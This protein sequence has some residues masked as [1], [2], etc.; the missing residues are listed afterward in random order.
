MLEMPQELMTPAEAAR[1]FRRSTSWLRRHPEVV[2]LRQSGGPP[3]YHIRTCR[4]YVL[5]RIC[6]LAG[7]ALRQV[8]LRALAAACGIGVGDQPAG[9]AATASAS[10]SAIVPS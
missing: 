5:G 1:W 2:H 9:A 10:G 3:L 6:G 7:E 4:A 8:Q